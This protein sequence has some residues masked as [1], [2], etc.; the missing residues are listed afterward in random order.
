MTLRVPVAKAAAVGM[1]KLADEATVGKAFT[2]VRG[3][4]RVKRTM[5]SRRAQE[6]EAKINSGDLIAISEVVRDL[7]RSQAQPEPSYSE[8]QLYEQAIDRM[9]R[10]VAVVEKITETEAVTKIEEG[11]RGEPAAQACSRD[12]GRGEQGRGLI[13]PSVEEFRNAVPVHRAAFLHRR[14]CDARLGEPRKRQRPLA[15]PLFVEMRWRQFV[16]AKIVDTSDTERLSPSRAN[17]SSIGAWSAAC[18]TDS[19]IFCPSASVVTKRIGVPSS[20]AAKRC[21]DLK[22]VPD[23]LIVGDARHRSE[24]DARGLHRVHLGCLGEA[25]GGE[26]GD[27]SCDNPDHHVSPL[28]PRAVSRYQLPRASLGTMCVASMRRGIRLHPVS[29]LFR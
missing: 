19:S 4:A 11:Y 15:G 24:R 1:R 14:L 20:P 18:G 2:T 29:H 16:I 23:H 13:C 26:R 10:E 3:R 21:N 17:S 8:R 25:G 27:K 9:S 22:I 7:Y 12:R 28:K 6:Y 5:W